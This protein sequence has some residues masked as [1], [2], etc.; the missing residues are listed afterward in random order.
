MMAPFLRTTVM[1]PR[2]YLLRP[3]SPVFCDTMPIPWGFVDSLAA[4]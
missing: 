2:S 1:L 3:N 4:R